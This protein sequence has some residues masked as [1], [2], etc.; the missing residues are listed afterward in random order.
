MKRHLIYILL[1]FGFINASASDTILV[2]DVFGLRP[3][4]G[5]KV[6]DC[7][8]LHT[9]I[10]LGMTLDGDSL[11][12]SAKY[13]PELDESDMEAG[14]ND[15]LR[16]KFKESRLIMVTGFLNEK[17]HKTILLDG[18]VNS[19]TQNGGLVLRRN[20]KSGLMPELSYSLKK[21]QLYY[22]DLRGNSLRIIRPWEGNSFGAYV[23]SPA[24]IQAY[25][26]M[27]FEGV[28][29]GFDLFLWDAK[30]GHANPFKYNSP[31]DDRYPYVYNDSILFFSSDR[32]EQGNFDLFYY[33][34]K[35]DEA[36]KLF[37]PEQL[38][39]RD[40]ELAI[41][42]RN[43]SVSLMA[44]ENKEGITY[45]NVH[46]NLGEEPVL[47]SEI[48]D[49]LLEPPSS[50]LIKI[51]REL[52]R[53][54]KEMFFVNYGERL[55]VEKP[56]DIFNDSLKLNKLIVR[57]INKV[58]SRE[59]IVDLS[60]LIPVELDDPEFKSDQ[61]NPDEVMAIGVKK[62]AQLMKDIE[63][64]SSMV[65]G[66]A[67]APGGSDLNMMR[68]YFQANT[69]KMQLTEYNG[70]PEENV[71]VIAAGDYIQ[72]VKSDLG[73]KGKNN[74]GVVYLYKNRKVPEFLAA[75]KLQPTEDR[76]IV[77]QRFSISTST[78]T[79]A[80]LM[81]KPFLEVPDDIIFLPVKDITM[82]WKGNDLKETAKDYNV[83]LDKL[84]K[85]NGLT[86]QINDKQ[87]ILYIP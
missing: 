7:P 34:F 16:E 86:D 70:I 45:K 59:N 63:G 6:S 67:S 36:P 29:N 76:D 25:S 40:N 14:E 26:R 42:F 43:D 78:M 55:I 8:W 87:R 31:A 82:V 10:F 68:S 80:E 2:K 77:A 57:T 5:V 19:A 17:S 58:M 22:V 56:E 79:Y 61:Y 23:N 60:F 28:G 74:V 38:Q 85:V 64:S 3:V 49:S 39:T 84:L 27:I 24:Y 35:T 73:V 50:D 65:I 20:S 54:A 30:T 48:P 18:D 13:L 37:F 11:F 41:V 47:V 46:F 9:D 21:S 66:F 72:S 15:M 75:Y 33:N 83:S 44:V 12:Y 71:H 81:I 32:I 62:I 1:L 52:G 53:R 4:K 69:F 51:Y